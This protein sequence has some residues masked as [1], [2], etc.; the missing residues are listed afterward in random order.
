MNE[1][2]RANFDRKIVKDRLAR[3]CERYLGGAPTE[4][5]DLGGGSFGIV[6]AAVVNGVKT[7]VKAFRCEGMHR[8]QAYETDTLAK[9]SLLPMPKTVFLHDADDEIPFDAMGTEFVSGVTAAEIKTTF[10]PSGKRRRCGGIVVDA[11]GAI[12]RAKGEKY[13]V[14]Q[15]PDC[16]RWLDFYRPIA[17]RVAEWVERNHTDRAHKIDGK[18][19]DLILGAYER[20]DEIFFE[21]IDRP[22]LLHGDLNVCNFMVDRATLTPTAL[23][24]PWR[25]L[26]G[27]RDY[28]LHQLYNLSGDRWYLYETYKKKYPT[29]ESVDLK[30]AFYAM[31]NEID[32]Y[33][34]SGQCFAFVYPKMA[35]NLKKQMRYFLGK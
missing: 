20:F 3:L 6:Y 7:V 11:L 35:A 33:I 28:D 17:R 31:F 13:G 5:T 9:Y 29:S 32:C 12:H 25:S 14:L 1:T 22:T 23:I 34:V 15:N 26:W 24:D 27:D 2:I 10:I 8:T 16:D 19:T 4:T 30:C 18:L 21:P